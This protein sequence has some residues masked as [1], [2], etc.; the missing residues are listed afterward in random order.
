MHPLSRPPLPIG[1]YIEDTNHT[2]PKKV[3][4]EKIYA[5]AIESMVVACTDAVIVNA[6][7]KTVYL[8]WRVAKPMQGWWIIGGRMFAGEN[9]LD[10]IARCFERETSVAVDKNRFV[11][12]CVNRY[13]WKDRQQIPQDIGEDNLAYTFSVELTPDELRNASSSLDP[14]EYDKSIGLEEFDYE[15]LQK[16]KVHP[17]IIDVYKDI[18]QV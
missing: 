17:A 6:K 11:L 4:D 12:R 3:L 14:D 18:F 15:R 1:L 16:E 9:Q 7:K 8:G 13:M 5:A 2:M 10:S